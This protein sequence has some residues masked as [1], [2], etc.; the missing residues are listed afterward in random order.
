MPLAL[1]AA[2]DLPWMDTALAPEKR[3]ALLLEAMTLEQKMQQL[4]G[5][6]P[7]IL[8]D[9]PECYGARHVT[10]IA[11]LAIPTLRITNGPVGVGQ[12]DCVD[13]AL[14]D[15]PNASPWAT[16]S[17]RSSAKATA[18]PSATSVAASFDPAVASMFGDV[19]GTE[20]KNLGLHVF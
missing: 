13:P 5:A 19:I 17:D 15:D 2:A 10:G 6:H 3:W 11:A 14:A 8:P 7:E 12:N 16:Y 18:L 4:T 1:A 20:I 9:L